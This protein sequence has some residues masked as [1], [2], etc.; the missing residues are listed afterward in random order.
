[1][2][3]RVTR[4]GVLMAVLG[5]SISCTALAEAPPGKV[6]APASPSNR[7]AEQL[8]YRLYE[9]TVGARE[10]CAS[11]SRQD[12]LELKITLDRFDATYP[13][14]RA[15]LAAS[16]YYSQSALYY[17]GKSAS[18]AAHDTQ[19]SLAAEC[20]AYTLLLRA[21]IDDPSGREAERKYEATLTPGS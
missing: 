4:V 1:M 15:L 21:L 9:L 17:S 3:S 11:T 10:R 5:G 20:R 14:L 12:S 6:I 18:M 16:P 2:S 13:R 19:Q 8:V 7:V